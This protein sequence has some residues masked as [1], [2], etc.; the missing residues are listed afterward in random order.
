MWT[1]LLAAWIVGYVVFAFG[2][3]CILYVAH[4]KG[5]SVFGDDA[6][7]DLLAAN[8]GPIVWPIVLGA[9]IVVGLYY[10]LVGVLHFIFSIPARLFL[11]IKK[12]KKLT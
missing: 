11:S 10:T 6:E 5:E 3:N 2:F 7:E 1:G 4:Q 9:A 8:L 12:S